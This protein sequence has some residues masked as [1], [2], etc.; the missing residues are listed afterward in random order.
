MTAAPTTTV[1]ATVLVGGHPFDADSFAELFANLDGVTARIVAWPDA[2]DVYEPGGLDDTDVLVLYDMPG[3]GLNQGHVPQPE[4]PPAA[5]VA[6]WDALTRRG[7]PVVAMHHAIASWALWPEFAEI[8]GGRFLYAPGE[9]RGAAQP[10]SGWAFDVTQQFTVLDAGHPVCAG[11]PPSFELTDETYLCP[12]FTDDIHPLIGTDAPLD[13]QHHW[14]AVAA[15][16]GTMFDRTGWS[17]A[18]GAPFAAWTRRYQASTVVYVQPGDGPK[19]FTNEH[20][21]RLLGNAITWAATTAPS[22]PSPS[23]D[24]T[25]AE[26]GHEQ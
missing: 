15:V 26:G 1:R 13:D 3:V 11:L 4:P 22:G 8:V 9:L 19:A 18:P 23:S 25:A 16:T 14:S 2:A 5:V 20:Y 21:R 12:V 10:D 24:A 7:Q 17:H 6:G